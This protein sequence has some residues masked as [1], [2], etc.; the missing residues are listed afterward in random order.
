MRIW[1]HE[2]TIGLMKH[3]CI[4]ICLVYH[5]I[6]VLIRRLSPRDIGMLPLLWVFQHRAFSVLLIEQEHHIGTDCNIHRWRLVELVSGRH[7]IAR[8]AGKNRQ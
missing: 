8:S 2:L 5:G 6:V 4:D 3:Y 7:G 1:A